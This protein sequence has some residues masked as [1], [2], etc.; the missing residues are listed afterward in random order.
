MYEF[1][2]RVLDVVLS[3]AALVILSPVM[4]VLF[5]LVA[6]DVGRPLLF[7]QERPGL[8]AAPFVMLKFRTMRD[9]LPDE[10]PSA[11]DAT[12]LTRLGRLLR[13]SSLDELPELWNVATGDMSLVGPRPLLPE[14]L[15]YYSSEQSER[16]DVR[17]GV[18]GWAQV[19]GRNAISWDEKLELD[20]WYVSHRSL[21]LDLRILFMTVGTVLTRRGVCGEGSETA[22]RF[23]VES[24]HR[25]QTK[26][27]R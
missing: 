8:H 3:L 24:E 10:D 11:T 9:P 4:L 13:R 12:R 5:G 21:L 17:P 27:H 18:T 16:H 22:P 19:N 20:R 7:R 23:D 2:K 1:T 25:S 14:Y 15:A 26:G 6:L